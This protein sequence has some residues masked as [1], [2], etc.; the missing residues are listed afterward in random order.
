MKWYHQA[1]ITL[2]VAC[3]AGGLIYSANHY[4]SLYKDEQKRADRAT[5]QAAQAKAITDNVIQTVKI[6]NA[7]SE[8]NQNAKNQ[9]ALDAQRAQNDI[10][11]AVTGDVCANRAVPA[12]AV[13]RVREYA[14]SLRTCTSGTDSSKPHC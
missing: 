9:I 7:I 3:L 8:A 1:L 6:I 14:N 4:H 13:N 5:E 10:K 11:V 12:G 2:F